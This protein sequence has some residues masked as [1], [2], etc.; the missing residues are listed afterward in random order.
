MSISK[1]IN[2]LLYNHN[3]VIVPGFG[4]FLTKN[5]AASR[6]NDVFSP[7]KKTIA[8]NGM[9]KENDGLLANK[10]SATDGVSYNA[11]LKKIKK[12]VKTLVSSLNTGEVE[13]KNI[14]ILRLNDEKKIQFQPN[15]N[16]N[17]DSRSY[18]LKVSQDHQ[19]K[20]QVLKKKLKS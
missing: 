18:G 16:V 12:D 14:G 6:N 20:L 15:Q 3:C 17:F 8:F 10:I 4:A 19:E 1:H 7:P 11:A 2:E 5:I 13:I 9:L